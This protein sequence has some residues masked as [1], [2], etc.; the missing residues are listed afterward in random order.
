MLLCL[1]LEEAMFAP[2]LGHASRS[3]L[4]HLILI[5][6]MERYGIFMTSQKHVIIGVLKKANIWEIG[7]RFRKI[8]IMTTVVYLEG[9][10]PGFA[11]S[12]LYLRHFHRIG[13]LVSEE[14]KVLQ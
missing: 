9:V 12:R 11:K 14:K 4:F 10:G 5:K 6:E 7:K 8:S 13:H 2:H 3:V 1:S